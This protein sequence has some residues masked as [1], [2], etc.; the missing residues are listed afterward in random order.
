[1]GGRGQRIGLRLSAMA[2]L[3]ALAATAWA[4]KITVP[5]VNG[6][7]VSP[8][9]GKARKATVLLFITNDCPISNSYAP[10]F[11]RICKAY[12]AKKIA[13]YL[14]YADTSLSAADAKKHTQDYGYTCLALLDRE[15][16]LVKATGATITPEAAVLSTEGKLLY[17][18]RID[19]RYVDFG[20]A[21]VQPTVR[22]LRDALDAIVQG[23]PVP[24]PT[25]KALGCTIPPLP[26]K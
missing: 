1:M 25:T 18:G 26:Q 15:H 16:L 19:D 17:R 20:K 21:R 5:D 22:D 23:K 12:T 2:A 14:V 13:F 24:H 9:E 6:N 3:L 7:K 8:L 11:T 4:A 10:E